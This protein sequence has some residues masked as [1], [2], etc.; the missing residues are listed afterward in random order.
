MASIDF[1]NKINWHRRYRSPQGVKTEHEILRIFES[2]RGRIIN[3]PAIRRLQQKTQVFPLERNAAVR[4]RLTHSMEVQQV[5]RYI[6]KEILSRLKEQNR[7]EEYGLDALTGP[8]ESIVEMACLMHDIGNP[9]FGHFGE[10]AIN[11]WFR[12]RLHPEDAESQPLTH[13]RCVVS[14]LRLQEGEENLNDIRRKVRQDICHFEGNA[15]G[16]RLVH[17]LMRMNL[18]WAQVGGILKYTRPAWWRGSVPDS[19]RYLMKK[20]GYYLSEE[21]Y[22]AR[23]RK[24][25]QLAPYSRF[26]LTWI[27]EAADDISYCVADLEDAVEKRIFSVEQLYHHL[28]HAWGHHEKDSLFELVVG[29]AWGKSRANTLSRSTEDQFF[30]YL[31]VNTLNKLVPYAAQR[32]IDNLPQI[33][34]GTFNQAL[35]EDASG[36]SRLLELYKNVAVEHV[37]SHPDVEQLEL[38]GYRVISGLL[39]IYQPLLSLSLNDFRELVEQDRLKR[40]PIES[41]LFQKL[42]TRHR[43]AYV[44]IVSKLPTDSAEYPVLEYYYR[45]RLIQDYISG[46]T[47]LYAWDEYRRLMAVE[48]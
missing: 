32:F 40:L 11:D 48:Q 12:Q 26:P 16:I 3:S 37:F 41:R 34:A 15:Q 8:F 29:N 24:E 27:M 10:A 33:F 14:S 17:T 44:E 30:M 6:A 21:K 35:L 42:S 20:P 23:L 19:H 13:D 4:T 47:D 28:Y 39:D 18:T 5:G 38:Q 45:C 1:R 31:R 9:P 7:L 25:L 43:L 36:F 22:I 46:M 2:D